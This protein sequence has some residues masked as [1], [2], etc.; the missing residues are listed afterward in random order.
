MKNKILY[1]TLIFFLTAVFIYSEVPESIVCQTSQGSGPQSTTWGL[2]KPAQTG[3]GEY[4]RI[5]IAYAQFAS[6]NTQD[7][8]WPLNQLPNWK[9]DLID[10]TVTGTY[11]DQTLSDYFDVASKGKFDFI[12]DVYQDTIII[13]T[14]MSY[15]A[16]NQ[17]VINELNANISD[18]SRYDNWKLVNGNH[19]FSEGNG[20]G[21]VDM[22]IIIYRNGHSS[23]GIKG[24]IANLNISEY[25]TH[26]LKKINGG[27][28]A[29]GSGIT[30]RVGLTGKF[31]IVGH[32]AHEFGHYLF[33]SGHT[34]FGGLMAGDPYPYSTE[35]YMMS[36]WERARLGYIN[37]SIPQTDGQEIQL[38]DFVTDV[39]HNYNAIKIPIPFN[40][41]S[42]ST[43]LMVENHQRVSK[44]DQ[45]MRGESLEGN[46]NL[47]TTL[48]QGL[49]IW[50]ITN[51]NNYAPTI[52]IK[53]AD[54]SWNWTYD[55]D[56]YAGPGWYVGYPWEGYLPKTYHSS[57]NRN[58]G[59]SDRYPWHLVWHN[60]W[61]SKWVDK[62]PNT[63]NYELT[64]DVMGEVNDA[65]NLGY[66][67]LLT[68]WSNPSSYVNGTT[69]ISVQLL[70]KNGNNITLKVYSTSAS[71]Q[72][73]PPSK[74]QNLKIGP[75]PGNNLVKLTW[76]ANAEPPGDIVLYE[77]SRKVDEYGTGWL[78]IATTTNTYY[79][80][81]EMYY[82]PVGGLVGSHYRIR[83]KDI[84]GL[85]SIY[86]DEVSVRTE[87]MNKEALFVATSDKLDY[88][89]QNYPNPFNPTTNIV[90]QIKEKGFVS[91]Q[92]FD[93]IGREVSQLV[94]ETKEPGVYSVSF[95]ASNLPSGVYI[96]SL[97][98]NDFVQNQK[99]TLLK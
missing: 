21:Y 20:D 5:L 93:I 98:V 16:A 91:L 41:P 72:S 6:D 23:F 30:T 35:T 65:F 11:R 4:F 24:G 27:T 57:V 71:A 86:S 31:A 56:Y 32:L 28:S 75:N 3:T 34:N 74:P 89:I 25:T 85:Y 76:T 55:G 67:E 83:A 39:T 54:G 84:Q 43:F 87:P 81:P 8:V 59:K 96:Y 17:Y 19:I 12:G 52:D 1:T 79:V 9:N 73:L 44:Y 51:G 92:V 47:T 38:G 33:G 29:I 68:P 99:M 2:Y 95:D 77:V 46:W 82:A 26:D 61:A 53:A 88:K 49:Y 15:G 50:V 62:N 64:R 78:V 37:L 14:N 66:V 10:N 63:G 18:F 36:A 60:Q 13:P 80:D 22:L 90:Y 7:T 94:K 45:I 40:N 97:R 70:S 48:G 58:T 42:S 69:D